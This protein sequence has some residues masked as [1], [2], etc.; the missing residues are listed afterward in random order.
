MH[1]P[2]FLGNSAS[3]LS[4]VSYLTPED[5]SYL[6]SLITGQIKPVALGLGDFCKQIVQAVKWAL[7]NKGHAIKYFF[8]L[9]TGL[10]VQTCLVLQPD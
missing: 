1:M 4:P 10:T 3:L 5:L 7:G 9:C 8:V 2:R 6:Q